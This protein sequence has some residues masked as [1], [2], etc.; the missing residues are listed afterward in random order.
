MVGDSELVGFEYRKDRPKAGCLICG[1]LFQST[2]DRSAETD[3]EKE[4]AD[5]LRV[6]W[7]TVHSK[8]HTDADHLRLARYKAT[9]AFCTP[10]AA[11]ELAPFGIFSL[12]DLV[13]SSEHADALRQAKRAPINDA[14]SELRKFTHVS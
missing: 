7:R 8:S 14:D 12:V 10:E 11:L 1:K 4:R 6:V 2:L 5:E 3:E 13:M 9:G